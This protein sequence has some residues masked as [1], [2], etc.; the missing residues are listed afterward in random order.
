MISIKL[1]VRLKILL[2]TTN[3]E[4]RQMMDDMH[5][6]F[7]PRSSALSGHILQKIMIGISGTYERR[8]HEN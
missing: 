7:S 2:N 3:N 8:G 1:N 6:T 4:S 5:M